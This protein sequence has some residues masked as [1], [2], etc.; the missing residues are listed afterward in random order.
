[1]NWTQISSNWPS[2]F[3]A[4]RT[5]FPYLS[6]DILK[7]ADGDRR[8]LEVAIAREHDL[9]LAEAREALDEWLMGAPG[10]GGTMVNVAA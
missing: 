1:M 3:G 9:T 2:V 4:L 7:A 5:R 8:T 6:D 10:T